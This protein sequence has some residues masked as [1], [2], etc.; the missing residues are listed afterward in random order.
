MKTPF[1]MLLSLLLMVSL[2]SSAQ[3]NQ[4]ANSTF[5]GTTASSYVGMVEVGYLYQD[6]KNNAPNTADSSPTL[7]L[8]NGYQFHRLFS[9]G[10]TVGL[11][12]YNQ[13]LVSPVALGIRGT[14]LTTRVSPTFGV[15][16]GYGT[17]FLSDESDNIKN[18]GG[19]MVNPTLGMRVLAGNNT[20][21]LFNLGYKI[22]RATTTEPVPWG[23]NMFITEKH[24]FK[25]LSARLGFMF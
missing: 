18:K 9:L 15:D 7:I 1:T 23:N 6:N 14:L 22:Q 24:S 10:A 21:F 19:W 2:T 5:N 16:A 13:V 25:R 20:A 17:T 11:D 8:F 4:V 12:F 3:N